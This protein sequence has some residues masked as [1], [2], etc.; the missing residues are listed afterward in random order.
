MVFAAGVEADADGYLGI[1]RGRA[2]DAKI[3]GGRE[4]K[5]IIAV[6]DFVSLDRRF[7]I[8]PSVFVMPWPIAVQAPLGRGVRR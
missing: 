3:V 7:G 4:D 1:K 2:G 5:A 8:R 6:G